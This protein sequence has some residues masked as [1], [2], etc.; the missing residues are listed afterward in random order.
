MD[1]E[2][3]DNFL[4]EDELKY[5]QNLL[6]FNPDTPFFLNPTV[7]SDNDSTNKIWNWYGTHV[8]YDWERPMSNFFNGVWEIFSPKLKE[9]KSLIRIKANFYPNTPLVEEHLP[10]VDYEWK[11]HGAIFSLNTC[12]GFTRLGDGTK[13]DSVANRILFFDPSIEHNSSTTSNE[14]GRFN[15]NFNWL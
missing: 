8:F 2:V 6:I 3:V 1:Y 12:D 11:H 10:H 9:Y 4:S 13:I 15:I 7:A 14:A 5:V